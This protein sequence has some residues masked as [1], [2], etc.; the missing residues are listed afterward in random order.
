MYKIFAYRLIFGVI[1]VKFMNEFFSNFYRQILD[2]LGP[3]TEED[4][5]KTNAKV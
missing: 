5:Q 4:M 1:S 3:K 2:L